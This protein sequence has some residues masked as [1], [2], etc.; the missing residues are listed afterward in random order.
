MVIPFESEYMFKLIKDWDTVRLIFVSKAKK[1]AKKIRKS[2]DINF[3]ESLS[4]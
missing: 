4:Q 2:K 3:G 1:K